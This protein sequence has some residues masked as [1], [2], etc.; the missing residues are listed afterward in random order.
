MNICISE[1]LT[2]SPK[3]HVLF[4]HPLIPSISNCKQMQEISKIKSIWN[5]ITTKY[6]C[7]KKKNEAVK[8]PF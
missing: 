7:M 2:S 8:Y 3:K 5:P 4:L 1:V 6:I